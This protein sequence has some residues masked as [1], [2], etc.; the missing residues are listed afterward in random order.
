LLA[1]PSAI[2]PETRNIL[3]N[4]SHPDAARARIEHVR[5]HVVDPRLLRP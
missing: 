2:I 1:V 3:F 4:P 5:E